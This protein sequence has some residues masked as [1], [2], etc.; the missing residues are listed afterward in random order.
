LSGPTPRKRWDQPPELVAVSNGAKLAQPPFPGVISEVIWIVSRLDGARVAPFVPPSLSPTP[1]MIGVL[2]ISDTPSGS[3][4]SPYQR[5]FGGVTIEGHQ[6]PDSKDAVYI[7][8][9]L[10]SAN[11]IDAW[12]SHYMDTCLAGEPRLW[13]EGDLLHATVG[14][15]GKTWLHA[16]ARASAAPNPGITGQDAYIGRTGQ[17]L[18]RHIVSYYGAVTPSE[19][20]SLEIADNAPL[21]FAALRPREILLGLTSSG[22]HTTWSESRPL[23]PEPAAVA[24]S[25]HGSGPHDLAA[26]LRQVGLTPAEARL[27]VLY[28]SGSSAREAALQLGISEHT[29]KSTL[30]QVYGKLG[31]RKQAELGRF[32]ARLS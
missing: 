27:A 5:A 15:N 11:A 23:P 31:V 16:V 10:V 26:L 19:I 20:L 8:G 14:T 17:G 13:R 30:K 3:Q 32:V 21:P 9:D 22:L 25:P 28:G 1:E 7:V 2:G 18:A 29:A 24:A 6:A 4:I 12:R